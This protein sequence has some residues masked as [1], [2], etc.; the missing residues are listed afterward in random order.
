MTGAYHIVI[1]NKRLKYEFDIR[2]N[3]TVIRGNS[4]TGKT[5]LVEMIREYNELDDTGIQIS[6]EKKCVVLYGKDWAE[7]L[8]NMHDSIVFIDE[9]SRFVKTVEFA[10]MAKNSDN[11]Y[12]IISREK[13]A[14]LPYSIKEIYGI[15][16]SGKYANLKQQYVV[17]ELY[18]IYGE[19]IGGEFMPEVVITE[20]SNAGHD[21]F[22]AICKKNQVLIDNDLEHK[23]G[24]STILRKIQKEEY[25]NYKKLVV[26]DGAAFGPEMENMMNYMNNVDRYQIMLFAPESF[27][28]LLLCS[29]LFTSHELKKILAEPQ[30]YIESKQYF[31]WERFF[32]DLLVN[33]TKDLKGK[34][35]QKEKLNP[36]YLREE[37]IVK[38][39]NQFPKTIL[40]GKMEI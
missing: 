18:P 2:R 35:Y 37:S 36:Y 5:T 3:I 25:K 38:I 21:F 39:V 20:D 24:N 12:V 31:S 6:C 11:Y 26:V 28:Y 4:A 34:E 22:E 27:E 32:T 15:R 16:E 30:D 19:Y 13:L 33:E 10:A 9:V 29:E 14:N 40:F 1:S 17:N 23:G 7:K 8:N